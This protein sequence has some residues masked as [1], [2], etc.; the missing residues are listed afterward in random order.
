MKS[1]KQFLVL[2]FICL[3]RF[4]KLSELA[5]PVR[6][7]SKGESP[8]DW[9]GS[10]I[11][12]PKQ[13]HKAPRIKQ[14][15]GLRVHPIK[16]CYLPDHLKSS[17]WKF[18]QNGRSSCF[19]TLFFNKESSFNKNPYSIKLIGLGTRWRIHWI[20]LLKISE[21]CGFGGNL[22][23]SSAGT[24]SFSTSKL[25]LRVRGTTNLGALLY[26][27]VHYRVFES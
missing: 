6:R 26:W 15:V 17:N 14:L 13:P 19:P 21:D 2:N 23:E 4:A 12:T 1:W 9:T 27:I 5:Q 11:T 3:L 8:F 7:P 22:F 10:K 18:V 25:D 16:F 24:W 20:R